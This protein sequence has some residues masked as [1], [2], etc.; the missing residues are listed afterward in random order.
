MGVPVPVRPI[1]FP[2]GGVG[3]ACRGLP[4]DRRS[5][6]SLRPPNPARRPHPSRSRRARG[7]A[8]ARD[9]RP[10]VGL[11]ASELRER[12]RRRN[13]AKPP[14][15]VGCHPGQGWRPRSSPPSGIR[16]PAVVCH[17]HLIYIYLAV[18]LGV[19]FRADMF[20]GVEITV[21]MPVARSVESI[22]LSHHVF[23]LSRLSLRGMRDL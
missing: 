16:D 10:A 18:V 20:S 23:D 17:K 7:A 2:D 1:R 8:V 14:R 5:R 13:G 21:E 12:L 22:V 11:P 3:A 4:P 19:V 15:A 6:R 9:R